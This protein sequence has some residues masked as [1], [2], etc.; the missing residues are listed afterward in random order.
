MSASSWVGFG[1]LI[2]ATVVGTWFMIAYSRRGNWWNPP[3]SDPNGE[4]RAHLGYFTLN[5]TLTFWVYDFRPLLDPAVFGWVRAG[6]F[7][8]IALNMAWRL[9][10]LLRP[11]RQHLS[12]VPST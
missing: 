2:L 1:A 6:L 8:L 10:L 4:H 5:L 11:S 9:R 3:D 7:T 12:G